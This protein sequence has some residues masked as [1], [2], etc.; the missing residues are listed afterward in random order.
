MLR[1]AKHIDLLFR[2]WLYSM[3]ELQENLDVIFQ[4]CH[5]WASETQKS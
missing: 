5:F 1:N 4:I 3:F 2:A